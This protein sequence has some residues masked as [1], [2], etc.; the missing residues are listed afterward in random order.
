MPNPRSIV[1]GTDFSEK[2]REAMDVASALAAALSLRLEVVH[3]LDLSGPLWRDAAGRA[4]AT[5]DASAAL[6]DETA[7]LAA[8]HGVEIGSRVELGSAAARVVEL[9]DEL[10]ASLIVVAAGGPTRSIFRVG[11]TA[12]RIAQGARVPVLMVRDPRPLSEWLRGAPMGIAAL[13]DNDTAGDHVL[14]WIRTLRGIGA[15][16]VSVLQGYYPDE[17]AARFGLASPGPVDRDRQLEAY[18]RRD[19]EHRVGALDGRGSV[20][21]VPVR[22][23]GRVAD[24]LV[25]HPA[26]RGAGLLVVGN[27]R[28]R[29]VARWSSVAAGVVH[30]AESSVL[31]VPVDAPT[32]A[33]MAL[34]RY[35]RV[36][37]ATDGSSF[38]SEA[39]RHGYGLIAG[40]G[41][42]VVVQV[43]T[44]PADDAALRAAQ[45][46][47]AEQIGRSP[48]PAN[49]RID[50]VFGSDPAEAILHEAARVGADCIV[51]ASHGRSGIRKLLLGSVANAVV[52]RSERPVL[53]VRPA[54]DA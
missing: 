17:A 13:V 53:I 12:E 33:A 40:G 26:A 38:A 16:N 24:H 52:Q 45:A 4:R 3:V 25:E 31:V 1:C 21:Y 32:A 51:V 9:A 36:L 2:A 7:R 39:L 10:G 46:S 49:T 19:L 27:H 44:P 20:E 5:A 29:G 37:V 8:T 48:V 22:A 35:R 18:L 34:P 41:E 6:A 14:D 30:L 11:G 50:V 15:S 28:A 42:L 43:L 23:V 47:L 54:G